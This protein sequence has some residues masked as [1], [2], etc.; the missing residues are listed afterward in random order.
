M[1]DV[2]IVGQTPPPINGQTTMIEELLKGRYHGIRLHHVR[3]KFSRNIEEVG[4]FQF[5]KILI[6]LS[7]FVDIVRARLR[8]RAKILYFPPAG[9]NLIAVI[10][11]IL[12]LAGTRWMFQFTVLHFHAAG[13]TEIYP[14]LPRLLR[15]LYNIAYRNADLAIFTAHSSS[16]AGSVLGARSISIVPNGIPDCAEKHTLNNRHIEPYVPCILFMGILCEGKGLLTLI[17]ACSLLKENGISFR[18]VCAGTYGFGT[19]CEE[20]DALIASRGLKQHFSFPGVVFNDKK[21]EVFKEADVFCFPSHYFAESSPVVLIEAMSF[22]LP[23]VTTNWRGIPDIVGG[24]GG[25][26]VVEPKRPDLVAECLAKLLTDQELR[27]VMGRKNRIW[28]SENGTI[29]KHRERIES[30]LLSIQGL[31]QNHLL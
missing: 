23:I 12:L 27:N 20:I 2:L 29:E 3:T 30:A 18:V 11:D 26:F 8:S 28:F 17:D 24:S 9:P 21:A 14:R 31:S 22:R 1:E 16:V 13:L 25:A 7:T 10:R 6:L 5:R 19:T 15:P 4:S